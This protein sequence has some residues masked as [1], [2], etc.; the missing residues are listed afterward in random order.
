MP[1]TR[2]KKFT[3][4]SANA[5]VNTDIYAAGD[6]LGIEMSFTNVINEDIGGAIIRQASIIDL[7]TV[8]AP[9]D[10][11]LFDRNPTLAASDNNEVLDLG[12]SDIANVCGVFHFSSGS[13]VQLADNEIVISSDADVPF[14]LSDTDRTLY[15]VCVCR[16]TPTY[17]SANDITVNL[18]IENR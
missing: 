18:L 8:K 12:D 16:G 4:A 3:K 11:L 14:Y 13:Y 9:I 2:N 1:S 6:Q 7:S 17:A 10:L 5:G 15:G